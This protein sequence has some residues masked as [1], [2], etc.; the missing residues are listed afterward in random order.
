MDHKRG[1]LQ[2]DDALTS[3]P[4]HQMGAG[5][6]LRLI[7]VRPTFDLDN[8]VHQGQRTAVAVIGYG[9]ALRFQAKAGSPLPDGAEAD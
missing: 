3:N 1:Q 2:A 8:L 6:Q 9:G 7:A 4:G 5:H